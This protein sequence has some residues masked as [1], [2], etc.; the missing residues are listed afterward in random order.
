MHESA[1]ALAV[2]Y[3]PP[4]MDRV[5]WSPNARGTP[6]NP[7]SFV[8]GIR[9]RVCTFTMAW[10]AILCDLSLDT[11]NHQRGCD[12]MGGGGAAQRALAPC[13]RP[14]E[15]G[16]DRVSE[17]RSVSPFTSTQCNNVQSHLIR[18]APSRTATPD[19]EASASSRRAFV[20]PGNSLPTASRSRL[21]FHRHRRLERLVHRW[22]RRKTDS[23]PTQVLRINAAGGH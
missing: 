17:F 20:D 11:R 4:S 6:P 23:I 21:L 8:A 19:H 3:V 2:S 13:P 7:D 15:A 12:A 5:F 14:R 18:F 9:T 1:R 22:T 16:C 10:G